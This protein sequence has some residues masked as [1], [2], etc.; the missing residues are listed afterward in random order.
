MTKP[1]VSLCIPTNGVVEWVFPVLDSIYNQSVDNALFEI[2]IT[3]NG[4]NVVFK[5]SIQDYL[6]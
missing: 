3:D 2:V 5:K 4:N 6:K 1:L